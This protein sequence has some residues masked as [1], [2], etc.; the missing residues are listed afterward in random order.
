MI[1]TT[2][3]ATGSKP[4]AGKGN[5]MLDLTVPQP[6][7]ICKGNC[8]TCKKKKLREVASYDTP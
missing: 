6:A 1:E 3:P 5:T 4:A 8:N 2:K 7:C